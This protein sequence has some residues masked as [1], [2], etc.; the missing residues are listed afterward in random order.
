MKK[1]EIDRI[2]INKPNLVINNFYESKFNV[3]LNRLAFIFIVIFIF[4][5]LYSSRVIYL[6]S[7]TIQNNT[8]KVNL[9]NRADITDRNGAY[10]SKSV[11][12][13]NVGIDPKLVKDKKKLLLKLKYTFPD[14]NFDEIKKKIYG[15]KFFYIDKKLTPEKY[16]KIKLLGEKSIRLEQ[17][18]TRIYP[19]K[20]LFSHVIGQ[21][22]DDN[23]GISGIEKSFDEKLKDGR[24]KL[25]LSLDKNLQFIIRSELL[26]AQKIFKNVGGAGILMNINNGE[27]LSLVSV[28]DFDLNSRKDIKDINYINR[29]TKGVYELGSV[30]K[31][32]TIAAGLNYG[33]VSAKDMFFNL[34][35][36]MKC[37]G[38]IISEYDEKLPKDLSVEDILVY[39]SNIGS[40]KIGEII[41]KEK[42]KE[43]LEKIGILSRLNF[44][45]EE[46]GT[47][48]PFKW[49]DCKLKT[50]SYGHGITTT[51]IQLAKGYAILANGGFDVNPTLIKKE[52]INK[53]KRILNKELSSQMNPI[54]RKVVMK[55]T[56]TL[57]DVEGL[58]VGGKTGTA[59][60]VE[61]GNYT[62]KKI[63]TFASIFPS[64][65]P[66]YVLIVL[67]EDTKLSKDYTYNYRNKAGSYKGTP[68]NTAG[69]TSVE[70]AGKI[71]DK[72]GPILATKY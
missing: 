9:I 33:L 55:G 67:L 36:K 26:N 72:I 65:N 58:E 61:N 43:F 20:N 22:D 41:G 35:K 64:S 42:L 44:D 4:V 5:I 68:F 39:S 52:F 1:K 59:Q 63:N 7:K 16:Q 47:P 28:P 46:M 51:P 17:K 50:I 54:F 21:I 60:I 62:N 53:K 66:K 2:I 27:I 14:K 19:D 70:I 57:S 18:I 49:R 12:T 71:I 30:F 31:S 69:W 32:F 40:V 13:S 37:G 29:A 23:N 10:I 3:N 6:S 25:A 38:R 8:Y 45:I 15:K 11:L 24:D 56:A 48:I 34:E